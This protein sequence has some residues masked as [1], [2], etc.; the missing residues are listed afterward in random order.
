[1]LSA[2]E[3]E[4]LSSWGYVGDENVFI[5]LVDPETGDLSYGIRRETSPDEHYGFAK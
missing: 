4:T 2:N 3:N 1:M 5:E